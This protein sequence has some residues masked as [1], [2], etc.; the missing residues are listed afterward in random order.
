VT[1]KTPVANSEQRLHSVLGTLEECRAALIGSNDRETALSV[2]V[3]ILKLRMKLNRMADSELKA[4]CDAISPDEAAEGSRE[5]K[6][7][8]GPPASAAQ[9]GQIAARF[10]EPGIPPSRFAGTNCARAGAM[11]HW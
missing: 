3:A 2:S 9:A 5:P 1:E 8:Q 7:V 11:P 10:F 4:L 6:S